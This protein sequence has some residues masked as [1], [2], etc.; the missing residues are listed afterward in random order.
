MYVEGGV[1]ASLGGGGGVKGKVGGCVY[2]CVCECER[3]QGGWG[4]SPA[5]STAMNSG[6]HLAAGTGACVL[7]RCDVRV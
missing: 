3:E 5:C 6:A 2:V 1:C 4:S 7:L